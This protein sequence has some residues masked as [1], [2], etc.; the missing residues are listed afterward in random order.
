MTAAHDWLDLRVPY[1]DAA[2][3]HSLSLLNQLGPALRSP[4]VGQLQPVTVIDIGAGTGNSACWFRQHLP[5]LL[6]GQSLRWVL[7]D[8]DQAALDTAVATLPD[9]ETVTATIRQLPSIAN[10]LLA[11][12]PG[13]LLVTGSAV[14]DVLTTRDLQAIIAT[15][16]QHGGLGL[17]LLSVTGQWQLSPADCDDAKINDAICK[18]QRRDGKLGPIAPEV[19]SQLAVEA[20]ADGK[21]DRAAWQLSR[22]DCDDA[23]IND[24]FCK[25]QRRDG[26]LGPIAPEVLSQLAVEADAEVTTAPAAWQL[27]AP[28][29][30]AFIE[31][32][33]TERIA[34][35][36]EQQPQ[37]QT[38]ATRWLH[39]RL[40]HSAENLT[41]AVDHQDIAVDA[42]QSAKNTG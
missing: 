40:Q 31:R 36:T 21:T 25:H 17:F 24:A 39:R 42:R 16:V 37:L 26:K 6:P 10:D 13:R 30:Q 28:Y 9:V 32:F 2:R 3:Q 41:V 14:L 5:D 4:T 8:T 20:E 15:L 34:A 29:D 19:L 35:A 23:K 12:T 22:A 1:D 33:L 27:T 18:H 11:S 38:V 7:I